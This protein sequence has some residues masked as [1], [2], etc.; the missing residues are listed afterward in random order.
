MQNDVQNT[1]TNELARIFQ[2]H[3]CII[4]DYSFHQDYAIQIVFDAP[5]HKQLSVIVN[6]FKTIS[7]RLLQKTYP[8]LLADSNEKK[9]W[10]Q[11][12][13]LLTDT[14]IDIKDLFS[15]IFEE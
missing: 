12:Y 4:V 8:T 10:A 7:S 9:F 13:Y 15:T 5:P 3:S 2:A 14:S 1:L 6:N 11:N